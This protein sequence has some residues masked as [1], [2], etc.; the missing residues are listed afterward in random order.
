MRRFAGDLIS[1]ATSPLHARPASSPSTTPSPPPPPQP[2]LPFLAQLSAAYATPACCVDPLCVVNFRVISVWLHSWCLGT[3]TK[4]WHRRLTCSHYNSQIPF[5]AKRS[6][7]KAHHRV[8]VYTANRLV[9]ARTAAEVDGVFTRGRKANAKN[10][11]AAE[12]ACT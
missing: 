6:H 7:F 1:R 9:D 5:R 11:A 12:Y 2:L 8:A 10:A 4:T 3:T